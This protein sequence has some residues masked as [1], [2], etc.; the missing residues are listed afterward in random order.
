VNWVGIDGYYLKPSWQFAPLFGPTIAAVRALTSDPILI[1]ET[2]ATSAAG[3]PAK[4]ADLFAGIR[5]YGLLGFVWFNSTN[6]A[7][8]DFSITGSAAIA[9]FRKAASSYSRPS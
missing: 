8:Q 5:Q 7:G 6:S 1:A 2:G 9:A 4:I 3:Q